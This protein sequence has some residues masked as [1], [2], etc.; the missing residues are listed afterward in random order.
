MDSYTNFK[1]SIK[2]KGQKLKDIASIKINFKKAIKP[3]KSL[4]L[5][6]NLQKVNF[7]KL[8]VL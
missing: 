6:I 5:N 8:L 4:D 1:I 2:L 3:I 7:I